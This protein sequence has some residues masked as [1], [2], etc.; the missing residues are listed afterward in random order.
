[1]SSG[2]EPAAPAAV[3]LAGPLLLAVRRLL[4]PLVRLLIQQGVTWP[5]LTEMLRSL[6]VEIALD[7]L[8]DDRARTDSRISL[9]TGVHRK[10]IR[11][12]RL[13]EADRTEAPKVVTVSSQIVARWLAMPG[14]Q[15]AE[16][17]PIALPRTPSAGG[18]SFDG[19]VEA[20]TTDVRP[21]AV[22]D[23]WLADGMVTVDAQDRLHLNTAAF[24]PR[25]GSEAQLFYFARNLHDHLAA[26]S[27]NVAAAGPA[28]FVD[29][30]VHYDRLTDAQA[31]RLEAAARA[32]AIHAVLQVN[33][34]ALTLLDTD[35]TETPAAGKR[36]NFGV[37]I[38]KEDE[39]P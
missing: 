33:R 11:R 14:Y 26:A 8:P 5:V 17:Q 28:P 12:L 24:V 23:S 34:L 4:R 39:T 16:G 10:E 19:L 7:V 13:L 21:R 37:Y 20:V 32:A 29:R 25:A 6:Y 18:P 35:P 38:Y 3:P 15:D 9:L 1:M 22:L 36:V 27:A 30:S 2:H 31:Q